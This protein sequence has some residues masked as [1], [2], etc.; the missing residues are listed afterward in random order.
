MA[1]SWDLSIDGTLYVVTIERTPNGKDSVR[2]NGRIAAK[3]IDQ[4]EEEQTFSV[5]GQPYIVRRIGKE[6]FEIL[7]DD[8]ATAPQRAKSTADAA[9][10]HASDSPLPMA[11]QAATTLPLIGWGAVV[12]MLGLVL[13][14]AARGKSYERVAS[15]RVLE[16]LENMKSGRNVEM[17][18]AVTIWTK[19]KRRL[20]LQE[21]SW[22][23][24]HFDRWRQEKG[25][26]QKA[27]TKFEIISSE[28]VKGQSIPTAI[29]TFKIEGDLYKVRVPKDLPISW[30]N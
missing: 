13:L 9:L 7:E 23:S 3:P 2:V 16:V 27:F 4:A 10:T 20:D 5:G 17:Q 22:G 6:S 12:A 28:M 15:D 21:M 29:V 26:Y 14:Y 1:N 25:L 19:N 8:W 18:F 11:K 30:E 24:D